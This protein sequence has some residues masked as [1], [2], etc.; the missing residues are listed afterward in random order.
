MYWSMRVAERWHDVLSIAV[1]KCPCRYFQH[2]LFTAVLILLSYVASI[3]IVREKGRQ[4][5]RRFR[6]PR[7]RSTVPT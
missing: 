1:E 4:H 5:G 6:I 2:S 3:L 7:P